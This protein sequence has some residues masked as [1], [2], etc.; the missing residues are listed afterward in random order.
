MIAEGTVLAG[1]LALR[2]IDRALWIQ[3]TVPMPKRTVRPFACGHINIH[4]HAQFGNHC[5]ELRIIAPLI[6][7]PRTVYAL[8]PR[9][10]PIKTAAVK[11]ESL[12][13]LV[14]GQPFVKP[15]Y[16]FL[17]VRR[18]LPRIFNL[19]VPLSGRKIA[20]FAIDRERTIFGNCDLRASGEEL[21]LRNRGKSRYRI[22]RKYCRRE[23]KA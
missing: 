18:R 23:N 16:R 5:G 15:L 22:G 19:S 21:I 3:R 6:A 11:S 20:R 17:I 14:I 2:R 8:H 10:R 9:H 1:A 7:K 4:R 12:Q 13:L